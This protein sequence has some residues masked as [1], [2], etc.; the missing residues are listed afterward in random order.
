MLPEIENKTL[1]YRSTL[2]NNRYVRI[3]IF[4]STSFEKQVLNPSNNLRVAL[5]S[6]V[7]RNECV[8]S[9]KQQQKSLFVSNEQKCMKVK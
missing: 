9:E 5:S 8:S 6:C 3:W 1:V 4:L 2:S 7:R